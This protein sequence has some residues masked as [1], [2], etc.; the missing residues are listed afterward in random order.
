MRGTLARLPVAL[1]AEAKPAQQPADQF[2][3]G[4]KTAVGQRMDEVALAPADPAE[5]GLGIATNCRLNQI[6]QRFQQPGFPLDLRLAAAARP[7]N[8]ARQLDI[9][10][11]QLSQTPPDR[12]ARDA[13]RFRNRR[14]TAPARRQR[15]IR[16][17]QPTRSLVQIRCKPIEARLNRSNVDHSNPPE[18]IALPNQIIAN[19]SRSYEITAGQNVPLH[20]TMPIADLVISPQTLRSPRHRRYKPPEMRRRRPL[21]TAGAPDVRVK[22]P[23]GS[24]A[25]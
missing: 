7:A 9:V 16:Y 14:D 22:E 15:F 13:R 21:Q 23:T 11:P 10:A 25:R 24:A 1:K 8:A 20:P 17:E 4:R 6:L 3:T 5:C 19:T 2:L 18:L 12:A